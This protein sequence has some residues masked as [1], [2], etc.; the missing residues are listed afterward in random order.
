M[1]LARRP[2]CVAV[3]ECGLDNADGFPLLD[4]QMPW[5]VT[6][7]D[8]ACELQKPVFLHERLAFQTVSD[9]LKS[10]KDKL[11]PVLVHCFTG[12]G[13]ELQWYLD[14]GCYVGFTGFLLNTKRA[15]ALRASI[16]SGQV[17]IPLDRVVVETD[18]PYMGF[19]KCR[20]IEPINPKKTSPNVPS[21]LPRVLA[22]VASLMHVSVDDLG[23]ATTANARRLFGLGLPPPADAT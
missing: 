10:R 15:A 4:Q 22:E 23:A 5:F 18:A 13:D 3:G 2:E 1:A 8:V 12:T 20:A 16:Q 7:L 11:P 17:S 19:K 6:Q 21:A 9:E 14:A